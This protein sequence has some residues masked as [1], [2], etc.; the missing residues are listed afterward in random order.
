[1]EIENRRDYFS[2]MI[3]AYL[4]GDLDSEKV[5]ELEAAAKRDLEIAADIEL[6]RN[7]MDVVTLSDETPAEDGWEKLQA[8]MRSDISQQP[9]NASSLAL[10]SSQD[11][12]GEIKGVLAANSNEPRGVNPFWRIA[13]VALAIVGLTQFSLS[14]ADS[15]ASSNL[16][17]TASEAG[18]VPNATLKLGFSDMA[19]LS[20]MTD[21]LEEVDG[22]IIN[23]PSALGLYSVTFKTSEL[24][25][26]AHAKLSRPNLSLDVET[27]SECA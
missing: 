14:G 25:L 20:D 6:Q 5:V 3:P 21:I 13:A 17:L 27:I 1:M 10:V 4:R 8:A 15:D 12:A 16:Y 11:K 26:G 7:L 18:H 24:C 9:K 22:K 19:L 2:L 23:G